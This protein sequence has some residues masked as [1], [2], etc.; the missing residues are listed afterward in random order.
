MASA[1]GV[2]QPFG[3]SPLDR[4]AEH[5]KISHKRKEGIYFLPGDSPEV[6]KSESAGENGRD[7]H[8]L[9]IICWLKRTLRSLRPEYISQSPFSAK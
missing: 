2:Q 6:F 4:R 1:S 5:L 7:F 8:N 9:F 3:D